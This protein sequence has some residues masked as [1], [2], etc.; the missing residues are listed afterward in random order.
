M[1]YILTVELTVLVDGVDALCGGQ[2]RKKYDLKVFFSEE[3]REWNGYDREG[4]LSEK[5]FGSE[6]SIK[7][8]SRN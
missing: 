8:P 3:N 2:G 6:I 4:K 5:Q 7:H 1:Q